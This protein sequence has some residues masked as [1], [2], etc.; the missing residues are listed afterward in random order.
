MIYLTTV[1]ATHERPELLLRTLASIKA[2][3]KPPGYRGVVVVE[4]GPRQMARDV[5]VRGSFGCHVRYF[6]LP[7]ANKSK[8]LNFALS[9]IEG[10]LVY[11]NDDDIRLDEGALTAVYEAALSLPGRFFLGGPVDM[12]YETVPPLWL[13]QCI[14]FSDGWGYPGSSITQVS[15]ASFFGANW[16]VAAED[17]IRIGGFSHRLGP[18]GFAKGEETEVQRLLIAAGVKAYY[19]PAAHIWHYVPRHMCTEQFLLYEGYRDAFSSS[20][21]H[22]CSPKKDFESVLRDVFLM[23]KFLLF[24]GWYLTRRDRAKVF[25]NRYG[26]YRR[27]GDLRGR[28]L[29]YCGIL[30]RPASAGVL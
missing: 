2:A 24:C 16:V 19:V 18:L 8:A 9:K 25:L 27:W 3:H 13:K 4:N 29:S 20:L 1:I 11:F 26:I 21:F 30:R 17:M 5:V 15:E 12:E 14:A 6:Y 23:M 22:R 10:G 28:L 7:E